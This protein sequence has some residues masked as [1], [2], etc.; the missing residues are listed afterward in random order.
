[1]P[2]TFKV[3]GALALR[4]RK[5]LIVLGDLINGEIARGMEFTVQTPEDRQR[6]GRVDSIEF[7]DFVSLRPDCPALV[8]HCE[9]PK[10]I[11]IW[12]DLLTEGLVLSLR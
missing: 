2:A 11:D 8:L 6:T 3:I 7:V 1:M 4:S 9:D 10:D 12:R 5:Q